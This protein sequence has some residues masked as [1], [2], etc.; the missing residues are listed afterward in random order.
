MVIV[1][2]IS[3]PAESAK[4]VG[5]CFVT[6]SPLPD[7]ITRRGP[8]ISSNNMDGISSL[9]IFEL[10]NA[11]L[12][13]GMTAISDYVTGFFDVPG[14]AYEIK[15]RFEVEEALKMIGLA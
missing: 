4:K 6:A 7:Y 8:Y 15:V 9:S 13:E 2:K 1:S 12:A 3:F 5:E 10:D 14:F 11:K